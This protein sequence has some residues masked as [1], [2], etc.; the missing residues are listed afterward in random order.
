MSYADIYA[1]FGYIPRPFR[2]GAKIELFSIPVFGPAMRSVGILPIV[3]NDRQAV[4]KVYQDAIARVKNGECFALAPEGT[5]Q[6]EPV[7]GKFKLGPFIF[8]INA[9]MPIVPVILAGTHEVQPKGSWLINRSAYHR[10]VILDICPPIATREVSMDQAKELSDK[11]FAV[12]QTAHAQAFAKYYQ[13][14]NASIGG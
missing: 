6:I 12:M 2:F 7:L 4:Y 14:L 5:R 13:Q 8:A 10:T 11:V 9:Q 3:R 1:T